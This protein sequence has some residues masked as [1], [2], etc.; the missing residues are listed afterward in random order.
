MGTMTFQ[1]P[2]T[3][4]AHSASDLERAYVAGGPDN[5]P[6]P[7]TVEVDP[8]ACLLRVTRSVD[9]S[10][11]IVVPWEVPGAGRLM[12]SSATLMERTEP[13]A[14]LIEQARGSQPAPRSA[15]PTALAA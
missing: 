8:D 7:T 10:G 6:W 13:Y 15:R 11:W 1:L 12:G 2:A 9:E 14:L 4:D 5:M 3:L